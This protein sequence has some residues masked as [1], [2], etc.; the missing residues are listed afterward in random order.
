MVLVGLVG[1]LENAGK[2]N[3][4]GRFS[5]G[6]IWFCCRNTLKVPLSNFWSI[7]IFNFD[8]VY[9][10]G[11]LCHFLRTCSLHWVSATQE[12][13]SWSQKRSKNT[14]FVTR[15]WFLCRT[16][17]VRRTSSKEKAKNA[18]K[19]D[20]VK[21]ENHCTKKIRLGYLPC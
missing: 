4:H 9:F 6:R 10:F 13:L 16:D 11:I 15:R 18:K 8:H 20:M 3:G 14:L 1:F 12:S 21:I 5:N 7:L 19:R 2:C 17:S